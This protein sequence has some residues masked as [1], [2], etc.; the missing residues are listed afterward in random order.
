MPNLELFPLLLA[1]VGL[2]GGLILVK[3]FRLPGSFQ[4]NREKLK[5]IRKQLKKQEQELGL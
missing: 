2:I 3:T 5:Q 1:I 4:K